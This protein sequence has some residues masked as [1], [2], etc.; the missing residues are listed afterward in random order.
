MSQEQDGKQS[1]ETI[2]EPQAC[3]EQQEEK[4]NEP[5][6]R[7]SIKHLQMA[8]QQINELYQR[9]RYKEALLETARLQQQYP[10]HPTIMSLAAMVH[11]HVAPDKALHWAAEALRR[12]IYQPDAW[13]VRMSVYYDRGEWSAFETAA[14]QLA[15]V[16]PDDPTPHLL[17][18]QHQMRRGA[19]EQALL[20]LE[21]CIAIE[22]AGIAYAT[23]SYVLA[24]LER[25]P[26]SKEA[27]RKA[28]E[29][30]EEHAY[31]L[32]QLAW[33]ADQRGEHDH[34][35]KFMEEAVRLDPGDQQVREEYMDA[36]QKTHLW[37]RLVWWPAQLFQKLQ[38]FIL[39]IIWVIFAIIQPTLLI[40][41]IVLHIAT[42][43]LSRFVVN[44][45]V[46]GRPWVS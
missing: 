31:T 4:A 41:F 9:Q 35:L 25:V 36:L 5:E 37:F 24:Q 44:W 8:I 18:A 12:D 30:N 26:E 14:R 34:S 42:Y 10:E 19:L 13:R 1:I 45:K 39:L 22:P 17:L 11:K 7:E 27:E 2:D 3:H 21:R 23:Y 20:S 28:L 6:D 40:G 33:A 15:I 32:M 46:Y 43:W 29:M 16:A 38:P